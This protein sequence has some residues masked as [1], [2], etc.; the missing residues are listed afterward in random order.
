M[1]SW[2]PYEYMR[3]SDERTRLSVDLASRIGVES[4]ARVID[5]GCGPCNSTRVLRARW[6]EAHVVG[7]DSSSEMIDAARSDEPNEEWLLGWIRD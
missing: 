5:L 6:P 1:E 7:L 4:P 2:D 3:F